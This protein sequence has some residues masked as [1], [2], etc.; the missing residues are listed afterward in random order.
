MQTLKQK[1]SRQAS[2]DKQRQ[3][4]DEKVDVMCMDCKD[5]LGKGHCG[6]CHSVRDN[7][8]VLNYKRNRKQKQDHE[9]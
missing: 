4:G 1:K 9:V 8:P 7:P 5:V 6:K 3:K 2:N